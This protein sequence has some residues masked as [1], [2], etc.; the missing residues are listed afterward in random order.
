MLKS[1]IVKDRVRVRVRVSDRFILS[2]TTLYRVMVMVMVM[3]RVRHSFRY[4]ID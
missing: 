3:V 1:L 2:R 4:N